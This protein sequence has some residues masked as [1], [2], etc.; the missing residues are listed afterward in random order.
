MDIITPHT[1]DEDEHAQTQAAL[2]RWREQMVESCSDRAVKA[3]S[4]QT[5]RCQLADLDRHID[6]L[7]RR[8]AH[9]AESYT[10]REAHP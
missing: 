6:I 7:K 5:M 10:L 3:R 2:K 4:L 8:R 1:V 9:I